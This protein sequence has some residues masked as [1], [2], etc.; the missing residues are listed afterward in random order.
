MGENGCS[1][2]NKHKHTKHVLICFVKLISKHKHAGV[3]ANYKH[4]RVQ[5]FSS[6]FTALILLAMQSLNHEMS[7]KKA[8]TLAGVAFGFKESNLNKAG[9]QCLH[10]C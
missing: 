4:C 6:L 9:Q 5:G 10:G 2:S 7:H 8:W 1:G 3:I